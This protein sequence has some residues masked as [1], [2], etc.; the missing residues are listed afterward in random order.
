MLKQKVK[1]LIFLT[2]LIPLLLLVS[3]GLTG[4]LGANP[5]EAI[6]HFTGDWALNFLLITLSVTPIKNLSG[7]NLVLRYRRMLGLYAF[8][9]ASLH[10]LTYLVLDQFFDWREIIADII[11]RPYITVGFT[12]FVLLLPLAIT[13]T[14]RMMRRL[15]KYWKRLH[16]LIYIIAV[17]GVLHYLWLVKADMSTP[18]IYGLILVVL[19]ALRAPYI[20]KKKATQN[21]FCVAFIC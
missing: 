3:R 16:Q 9:Y 5:I 6:T 7:Y 19:L 17:L 21:C 10:F 4:K 15:G 1:S 12:A 11:D 8:F 18:I 13:S 20:Y 14:N 2:C